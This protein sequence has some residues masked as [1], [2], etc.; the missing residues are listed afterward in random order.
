MAGGS[1][2]SY[3]TGSVIQLWGYWSAS[4]DTAN[5]RSWFT[6]K[7]RLYRTGTYSTYTTNNNGKI[8]AKFSGA[9]QNEQTGMEFY[10][11]NDS[12]G[13]DGYIKT[14]GGMYEFGFWVGHNEDGTKQIDLSMEFEPCETTG[15]YIINGQT[16]TVPF[17]TV[18][19]DTIPRGSVLGAVSAFNW[20]DSFSVP[21]TKYSSSFTD[22]LTIGI[23]GTSI[24]SISG[25]TS[26][27]A[28]SLSDA[29]L[30]A[31]YNALGTGMNATASFS[32]QTYSGATQIGTSNASATGTAAGTAYLNAGGSWKRTVPHLNAGGT[33]KKCIA[34]TNIGGVWKR[35]V[36]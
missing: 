14:D 12:N 2:W 22:N 7:L 29:E 28:I 24:K 32:L 33:W 30:L 10:V 16:Y 23:G 15:S 34:Y 26:G 4:A 8:R 35:C 3:T 20:E 17:G 11:A 31:A 27:A 36:G 13:K 6:F 5:N 9:T 1:N 25:Y 21:V 19:F 18:S